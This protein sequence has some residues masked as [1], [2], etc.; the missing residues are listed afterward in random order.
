MSLR[1][2]IGLLMTLAALG[3]AWQQRDALQALAGRAASSAGVSAAGATGEVRAATSGPSRA[4]ALRKCVRGT[5]VA[6]TDADCPAGFAA[7]QVKAP[8]VN[9][10]PAT[11][12][13]KAS[14]AASGP[15]ALH[16]A[17]DM[18]RDDTL[19]DK[20]MERQIEGAR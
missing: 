7:A 18:T 20:I 19:R 12:V 14:D 10:V 15:T 4:G 11:P 2:L 1:V 8:P 6:Y 5:E 13:P 3:L 16:R 9:V 17:L